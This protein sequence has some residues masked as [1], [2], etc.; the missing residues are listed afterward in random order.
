VISNVMMFVTTFI[1][2][3]HLMSAVIDGEAH[4]LKLVS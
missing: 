3:R 4:M 1:K 2:V